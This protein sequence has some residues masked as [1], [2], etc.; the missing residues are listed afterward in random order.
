MVKS[1]AQRILGR[2]QYRMII[3]GKAC[4]EKYFTLRA[5]LNKEEGQ[6]VDQ[7]GENLPPIAISARPRLTWFITRA[8]DF[9]SRRTWTWPERSARAFAAKLPV[10]RCTRRRPHSVCLCAVALG[11][12]SRRQTLSMPRRNSRRRVFGQYRK[13]NRL[14]C[15]RMSWHLL[16][17][18]T[19]RPL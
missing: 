1:P 17:T 13:A 15:P 11:S 10:G 16:C 4:K 3:C 18:N 5:P 14:G 2:K 12:A 6:A 19:A 8:G 9:S 7:Q